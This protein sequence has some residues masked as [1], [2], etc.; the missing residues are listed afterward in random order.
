M[1][2]SIVRKS[3]C[4]RYDFGYML[5]SP[6]FFLRDKLACWKL[7][8][9]EHT[10]LVNDYFSHIKET[11]NEID[12]KVICYDLTDGLPKFLDEGVEVADIGSTKKIAKAGDFAISRLRS[13]LE[14][15]GIVEEREI[16]QLF[17]TEFLIFR[18]KTEK[19]SSHTLFT[20]C[21][22]KF[23]QTILKRGQYGTEH[24]RFYD[25]LLTHLPVPDCLLLL[26]QSIKQTIK[27]ALSLRAR[28]RENHKQAEGILLAELGLVDWRPKHCLSFV[29]HYSDTQQAGRMDADYFQPK[30]EE[31]IHAIQSYSGGYDTLGNLVAIQKCVEVGSGE[32]LDDGVPFVRVSNLSPFEITEEKYISSTLYN[33][34]KKHQPQCGEILL[35]KD[36]TPGMAYYLREQP[37]KMILSS[38]ILRLKRKT[39]K[40]ND[41]YLMLTLNSILTR[42]QV[43]RD[44]GGSVILHWRP[45]QVKGTVIPILAE[46]KQVEI[47]QKVAEAFALRR[48]STH[49]LECAKRSVEIAIEQGE[50]T[51]MD[52]L[53]A[54]TK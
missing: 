11:V 9:K 8:E 28:S 26:D 16:Q 13:Y 39:N 40:I 54:Q 5:F 10:Y 42:Q 29:K 7:L 23:V 35:T 51:A 48:R 34:L 18:P 36:A 24:P 46:D 43:A 21:M 33:A 31:I 41:D 52:W 1:Q 17:S 47:Q 45:E 50:Q 14:E 6:E 15:M 53:E 27:Q 49:L 25:F 12:E 19:L 44:V 32:Y 30:Y 2:Y 4:S 20:L 22:T 38:G 3:E 37:S